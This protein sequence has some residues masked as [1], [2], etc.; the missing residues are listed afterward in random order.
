MKVKAVSGTILLVV[1]IA[2]LVIGL[3]GIFGEEI[4]RQNPWI[5]AILG[6]I[7]FVSGISLLKTVSH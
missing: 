7:F 2:G 1:G 3:F 5:F 6:F 4:T